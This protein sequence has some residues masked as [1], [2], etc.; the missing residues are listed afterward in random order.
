L[1]H[2][3]HVGISGG[4]DVVERRLASILE[5]VDALRH[6][7]GEISLYAHECEFVTQRFWDAINFAGGRD[8]PREEW[9]PAPLLSEEEQESRY[10][11]FDNLI[12]VLK[13]V[14]DVELVVAAEAPLLYPDRAKGRTFTPDEIASMAAPMVGGVAHQRCD[15]V[16]LS[17]AEVYSLVVRLL[18]DKVRRGTWPKSIPYHYVDGP[19]RPGRVR[20]DADSLSLDDLYGTCLYEAAFIGTQSH[21]P[22]EIQVGKNWLSPAD[23]MATVGTRLRQWVHGGED[24]APVVHGSLKQARHV[25]DHV[26]WDW[27]I[28]PPGFDADALLQVG[29]LQTWTLKPAWI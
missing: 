14:P 5:R 22:A 19:T 6:T 24:D 1:Q 10:A 27:V 16:W 15:D 7:G 23:F 21:M 18:A 2:T 13:S 12:Q 17:P 11:A 25:P 9:Q 8:T 4:S 29:R 20:L 28:F 3:V 26:S